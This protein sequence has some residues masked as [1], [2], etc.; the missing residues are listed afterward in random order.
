MS[1]PGYNSKTSP[2]VNVHLSEL[3]G[4]IAIEDEQGNNVI[5]KNVYRGTL[6]TAVYRGG[7]EMG[8]VFTYEWFSSKGKV[9]T[10]STYAPNLP[11]GYAVRASATGYARL[12]TNYVNV[13]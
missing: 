13:E 9:A 7:N 4:Y 3:Q 11:D 1:A 6:L 8:L 10:G 12:E 2:L 5:G